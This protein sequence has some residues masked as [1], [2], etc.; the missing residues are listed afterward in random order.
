MSDVH[1]LVWC[2]MAGYTS[3]PSKDSYTTLI[4]FDRLHQNVQMSGLAKSRLQA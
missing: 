1:L 2:R 3:L 4:D